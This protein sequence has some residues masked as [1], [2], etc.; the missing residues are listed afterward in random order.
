MSACNYDEDLEKISGTDWVLEAV[1]ERLD[2][3]EKL[4]SNLL[5]YLKETAILTSNTS[6]IPLSDLAKNLPVEVKKRFMSL[7]GKRM[8]T[9]HLK[10]Q[11][12]KN[13]AKKLRIG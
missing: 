12:P 7:Q 5:P 1:V 13:C 10:A 6:G 2:I 8:E 9:T 4:Y 11:N 3:K